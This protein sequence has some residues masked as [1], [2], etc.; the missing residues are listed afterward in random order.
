MPCADEFDAVHSA[1]TKFPILWKSSE[2]LDDALASK[3]E[4]CAQPK[5]ITWIGKDGEQLE[6]EIPEGRYEELYEAVKN[7]DLEKLNSLGGRKKDAVL[8][9]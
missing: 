3:P 5:W 1:S 2:E 8:I 6:A 7:N 9:D 4:K